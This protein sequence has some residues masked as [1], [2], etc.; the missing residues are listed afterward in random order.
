MDNPLELL[1]LVTAAFA[2]AILPVDPPCASEASEG[3]SIC[4]V[5]QQTSKALT[6]PSDAVRHTLRVL[7]PMLPAG[8]HSPCIEAVSV[9]GTG[10]TALLTARGPAGDHRFSRLRGPAFLAT[11]R[12]R[13]PRAAVHSARESTSAYTPFPPGSF[14]SGEPGER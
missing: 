1:P 8:D 3:V 10:G 6:A 4:D 7:V 5:V 13:P 2:S 12:G 9:E 11:A 14:W